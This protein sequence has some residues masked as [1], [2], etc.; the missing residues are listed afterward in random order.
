MTV[1][2]KMEWEAWQEVVR[3]LRSLGVEIND[4][5]ELTEALKNWGH[6]YH[7]FKQ[8]QGE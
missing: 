2:S 4:Q 6:F 8:S 1:E 3:I 7:R 5:N